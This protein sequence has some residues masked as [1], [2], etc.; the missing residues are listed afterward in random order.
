[1]HDK[2]LRLALVC[3]GGISLAV[4]MHGITKEIWHAARASRAYRD[5]AE[6]SRGSAAIYRDLL[7]EITETSGMRLRVMVD[8]MAGAS[9]GG[10]N[11][12]FL[13]Q[14]VATGQSLD[15]LTDLWLETADVEALL[16][17]DQAPGSR[18]TKF[19]A[20][21]IAW[22]ASR[23]ETVE[24]TVEA[25]ARPEVRAKL[26]KFVRSRWFEP[27]FGGKQLLNMMLDA[28]DAMA[29]APAG[30]R[31]L[32]R[33]QPLDLFVTVTDFRGHPERLKLNSP[34]EVVETEHRLVFSFSDHGQGESAFADIAEL[35]F[36]ARATS[37]FPGAFPP[38]TVGELDAVL[39]DRGRVWPGREAFLERALPRQYAANAVDKAALIDGSVL[40]N[41]PFR[42]AMDALKE[43]PARRQI[44]RRFVFL[45]PTPGHRIGFYSKA[46][47]R[48]GFFQ[49]IIGA[50]SELPR[51]QP[52][53]DNLE[54][55]GQRSAR[56]E[57]M[58]SIIERIREE[59]E[60]QVESLFGYTLFLDYPTPKRLSAWRGRA[61]VAAA[62]KAGYGHAAYGMLKVGGVADRIATH[63]HQISDRRG[64]D[65]WRRLRAAI[66]AEIIAR[67]AD[68]FGSGF[69]GS[70]SPATIELL[71]VHDVG[72]RI[73]RLR[74]L[75]RRLTELDQTHE[76]AELTPVREAIY[77]S[78]AGYLE[79]QRADPFAGLREASRANDIDAASLMDQLAAR[80][81]LRT[82]D[83]ETDARLSV[84][85]SQLSKEM[86]R[87]VLLAYLGFPFFDIATLPLLQGEGL[88]EFDP[89]RVDRISPADAAGI[90]TGGA[91]ATLKGIQFNNF[92]AFFSRAYREN[93]YLWGRLHGAERTIDIILS[94]L[95]A[96][97]GLGAGRATQIKRAM[98]LAILDEE[99]PRLTAIPGLFTQLRA[100]IG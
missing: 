58:L 79:C 92:G 29:R 81:D 36:A 42:P 51:Q 73:R 1:M 8:I 66:A 70:A 85:L 11:S 5:G 46:P 76:N 15:P 50:L 98:F 7:S 45:D 65:H 33:G 60:G 49:T 9:A 55:I 18:F 83:N 43:R 41:A 89:I 61:Q 12:V 40:A 68:D 67:G 4:Y 56:I 64:Q 26:E 52:I 23:G 2:E 21:P 22:M 54:A 39:K 91:E 74:L 78:L 82:L 16:D 88:D 95:P 27:P 75:A 31:L 84:G 93:D 3:Y 62:S 48:P 32:P 10:I 14:A 100:E 30:P 77:E 87:P 86:R 97:S 34:P 90:R 24:E 80:M 71:R 13:A 57:R 99:E 17:P 53:R 59:V 63:L 96:K 20:L 37:S 44:D 35:A 28:F 19:W 47:E 6:A 72:F 25:D 38:A 69:T 94:T